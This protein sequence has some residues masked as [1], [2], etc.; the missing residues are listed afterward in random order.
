MSSQD[1]ILSRPWSGFSNP[2]VTTTIILLMFCIEMMIVLLSSHLEN[3]NVELDT[4]KLL[5]TAVSSVAS[6]VQL[7]ELNRRSQIQMLVLLKFSAMCRT[8]T[9]VLSSALLG[10]AEDITPWMRLS[11]HS[12]LLL[13]SFFLLLLLIL[14]LSNCF[15]Y[16][17]LFFLI[18]LV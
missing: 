9:H 5:L 6:S 7:L 16:I 18:L 15:V 14:F 1:L 11:A 2:L 12:L 4:S 3:E 17:C 10:R 13:L 8:R